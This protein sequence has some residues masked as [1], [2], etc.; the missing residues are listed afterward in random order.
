[1][2][3]IRIEKRTVT[4]E[5]LETRSGVP[6]LGVLIDEGSIEPYLRELREHTNRRYQTLR[7]NQIER[8]LDEFHITLLSPREFSNLSKFFQKKILKCV[9]Q[10]LS[11]ISLD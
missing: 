5:T 11:L 10:K 9:E 1:M 6:Y 7:N 3:M 8:D 2:T 4:I